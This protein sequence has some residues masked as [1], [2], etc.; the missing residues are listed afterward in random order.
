MPIIGID[1]GCLG[2]KVA[3]VGRGGVTIVRN[4]LADRVTPTLVSYTDNERLIGDAA[5]TSLKSNARSTI[6]NIKHQLG[7]TDTA[8]DRDVVELERR[9][10]LAEPV[11][12]EN[13]VIAFSVGREEPVTAVAALVPFLKKVKAMSESYIGAPVSDCV[14]AV[15]TWYSDVHKTAVLDA[16]SLAGIGCHKVM[17]HSTATALDYGLFRRSM[18]VEGQRHVVV[19]TDIGY[20]QAT[21]TVV[22]Y[23]PKKFTVLATLEDSALGGRSIDQVVVQHLLAQFKS[24]TGLDPSRNAKA[25]LKLEEAAEK[26]KKIL[27]ANKDAGVHLECFFEDE[28]LDVPLNREILQDLLGPA[29]SVSP[30]YRT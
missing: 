30:E 16:C 13:R 3:T 24:K 4:D 5:F 7:M 23:T 20:A 10:A 18:F 9:F 28:D 29:R 12:A 2:T 19:F 8:E 17:Q 14:V 1:L 27:S 11:V 25:M 15:P 21:A 22:D 26:A 6:R